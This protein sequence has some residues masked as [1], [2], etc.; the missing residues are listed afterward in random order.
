M[1]V[2]MVKYS[3]LLHHQDK[4]AFMDKLMDLGLVHVQTRQT[5]DDAVTEDLS[6]VIR[7]TEE[8]IRRFKQRK[9][10]VLEFDPTE[11]YP[12]LQEISAM[13]TELEKSTNEV[14]ALNMEL[15]LLEPWGDFNRKALYNLEEKTGLEVKFF[16]YPERHFH[17]VWQQQF[18][19]QVVNRFKGNLYFVIFKR[20][21]DELP[22]SPIALPEESLSEL[23]DVRN[24]YQNRVQQLNRKLDFYASSLSN[25]LSQRLA[26]AR[27]KLSYHLANQSAQPIKDH[28]IWLVEAWCPAEKENKLIEFL[29]TTGTVYVK[30]LPGEDEKPPVLLKNNRFAKLFEP[31]GSMFSLPDYHE[32]DLTVLFAPFF[33]LFFGLCLGDA[34]YGIIIFLAATSL[35]FKLNQAYKDYYTLGQLFG[36]STIVAGI[37]SGT[38]FGI[39]LIKLPITNKISA[40]F[41]N[42]EQ[43]F[44]LALIIGFVQI[45][46][47][48]GVQAYGRWKFQGFIHAVSRIGWIVLLLCLVDIYV[49]ELLSTTTGIVVWP[50]LLSIVLFGAPEKGWLKS[51]GMGL[52]DLYNIT[53]VL[54]DLL[55]YIRLF[56]LGVASAILGLVVNSIALSMKDV[57]YVGFLLFILVLLVGH[58]I[59]F[60]L[61]TLSAFV[62]PM[63]LTFV[64]FYKNSGFMGGGKPFKPFKKQSIQLTNKT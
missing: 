46:F 11:K 7:E 14:E 55:S 1:I 36:L 29:S 50:A 63:R 39:E 59:N 62:H 54:G 53:G 20:A 9:V 35:K 60:L 48:M 56:A 25:V 8:A 3:M 37:F 33:L 45:L 61:S 57:P 51:F 19:L 5:E 34:G 26:E 28:G 17:Q 58:L 41:L 44:N 32:L 24:M 4:E 64:E 30:T 6:A 13:E 16:Q 49:T 27:D 22:I 15:K 40:L 18:H 21:E 31:I 43:L 10:K 42:Q 52:A 12:S 38:F 2:P 47:G 23:I